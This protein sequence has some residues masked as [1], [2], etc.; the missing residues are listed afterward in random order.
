LRNIF[1]FSV[2]YLKKYKLQ[3]TIVTLL[4]LISTLLTLLTP[5]IYKNIIDMLTG[6]KEFKYF[7]FLVL[8]YFSIFIVREMINSFRYLIYNKLGIKVLYK[9][10]KDVFDHLMKLPLDFFNGTKRGEIISRVIDD[11]NIIENFITETFVEL[12][13]EFVIFIF[14]L[15]FML[16]FNA[17]MTIISL[18]ALVIYPL[19]F[20]VTQKKIFAYSTLERTK[21]T[22]LYSCVNESISNI[23]VIKELNKKNTELLNVCKLSREF[24]IAR[25]K[26]NIMMS[27]TASTAEIF[28]SL[29][30][31]LIILLYGGYE[32]KKGN[33]TIG[34]LMAFGVYVSYLTKPINTF[35]RLSVILSKIKISI[36]R[37]NSYFEINE[38]NDSGKI[39]HVNFNNNIIF[40]NLFFSYSNQQVI[41]NLNIE[42]KK[43][44]KV[45]II[46]K[47]GAGKTTIANLL[48]R[49]YDNYTG[50]IYIDGKDI[51]QY[52]LKSLR[53]EISIIHQEPI[54]FNR[55]IAE[56]LLYVNHNLTMSEIVNA[57]RLANIDG[58]IEGLP[59]KYN[60]II[61]EN[62]TKLSGGQ[63]QRLAI[64]RAILKDSKIIIFDEASS[65]LDNE[66]EDIIHKSINNELVD[67][68]IIIIAHRLTTI[69]DVDK[70]F[71]LDKKNIAEFGSHE[72]L[73][74][75]DGLYKDLWDLQFKEKEIVK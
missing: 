75:K 2:K 1:F 38:E 28:A 64:A 11:V 3:V 57:C 73:Y 22:D 32:I 61:G 65:H 10:R 52:S 25:L 62:G 13:A 66:S 63:K 7:T 68:T 44:E 67:K 74:C 6:Q 4:M 43:N 29:P 20:R 21:S 70:I 47:S 45:A 27:L 31:N 58:Y 16:N 37:V 41:E 19:I 5:L 12:S 55:S 56:N 9:I 69:K 54:F 35:F 49:F 42:I 17:K 8:G 51:R 46:G 33:L 53:N 23:K 34:E 50:S 59:Q 71:V 24:G 72:Q 30:R 39:I 36:N 18:L 26:N 60:T 48:L 40:E 15:I 14:S